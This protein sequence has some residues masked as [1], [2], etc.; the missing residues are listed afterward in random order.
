MDGSHHARL[1]WQGFKELAA[2]ANAA[3][4]SLS[5]AAANQGLDK[6]LVEL[7]KLRVS[8]INGCAFCVA[9]HVNAAARLGVAA[10]KLHMVAAWREADGFNGRERAALAWAEALTTIAD[11]VPDEAY[12]A[13][14]SVFSDRELAL[15]TSSVM[16]I[17]AW[18]RL[19]VAYRFT[20]PP[21]AD[22]AAGVAS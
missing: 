6:D 22:S 20:P 5:Q 15:L 7:V 12:A 21:I 8:Q 11:G 14:C 10:E 19:G 1:E 17:N 3:L 16:A 2:D 9:W 13:A 4:L 18:N